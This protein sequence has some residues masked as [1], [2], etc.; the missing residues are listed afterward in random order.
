MAEGKPGTWGEDWSSESSECM[1]AV[2]AATRL[3]GACARSA[4]AAE[5]GSSCVLTARR[6]S[7]GSNS[8]A[9]KRTTSARP[10]MPTCRKF[11]TIEAVVAIT[12]IAWMA[13]ISLM[14]AIWVEIQPWSNSPSGRSR[15]QSRAN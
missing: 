5:I 14:R 7:A 12:V 8:L 6:L 13:S 15:C 3:A 9:Q 11:V 10:R 1:A 4:R 2:D